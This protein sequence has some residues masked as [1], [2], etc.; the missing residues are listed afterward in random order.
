MF[1]QTTLEERIIAFVHSSLHFLLK[2]KSVLEATSTKFFVDL[3]FF[4]ALVD[5]QT[6]MQEVKVWIDFK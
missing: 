1:K 3:K 4:G 6:K 2:S 5:G